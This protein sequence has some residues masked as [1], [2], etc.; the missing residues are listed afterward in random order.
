MAVY[1]GNKTFHFTLP[2]FARLLPREQPISLLPTGSLYA[3]RHGCGRAKCTMN[4]DEVVK[5]NSLDLWLPR[6]SPSSGWGAEIGLITVLLIL[7]IVDLLGG[8][9]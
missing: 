1:A 5:R 6:N 9:R 3:S 7:L 8:F 2:R 4:L